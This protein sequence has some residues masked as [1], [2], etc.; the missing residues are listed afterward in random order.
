M[1]STFIIVAVLVVTLL[2]LI[3]GY[4]IMQQHK[5]R[6]EAERKAE[7]TRQKAI[8]EETEELISFSSKL[9]LSRSLLLIL[10]NR[11]L[12]ALKQLM[13]VSTNPGELRQ[14]IND[15]EN[16]V[17]NLDSANID[18]DV[19][20]FSPPDNDKAAVQLIQAIK[21]MRLVL[22]AEHTRGRV[23]PTVFVREEKSLDRLQIVISVENAIRRALASKV[24]KQFPTA[25][26]ML[27]KAE[28]MLRNQPKD[29][30]IVAKL[31]DV[32][33][34]LAE[35]NAEAKLASA[36]RMP[37]KKKDPADDLDVIFA[38]KKKW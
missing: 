2:L 14:R 34:L 22:R 32:E 19:T 25:K 9:P 15:S 26:E 23:D 12:M 27:T 7:I 21:K 11:N 29:D 4:N 1:S 28:V 18:A 10:H 13:N 6:V 35:L 3:I 36:S 8:I 37:N 24:M 38:P 17:T 31:A 30:Y 33:R 20:N 5:E 16:I